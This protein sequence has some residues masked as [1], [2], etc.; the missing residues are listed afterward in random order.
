MGLI[1][2]GF[3]IRIPPNVD[4]KAFEAKLDEWTSEE[5][6]SYDFASRC[7]HKEMTS[8]SEKDP[9]WQAF[10]GALD[11]QYASLPLISFT[12]TLLF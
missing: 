12:E 9:W 1:F 5:G 2:L 10:K 8:T 7:D 11:K 6:V 4:I 3:D